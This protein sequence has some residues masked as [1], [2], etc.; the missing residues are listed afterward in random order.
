[1]NRLK[2]PCKMARMVICLQTSTL[3]RIHVNGRMTSNSVFFLCFCI[4][5]CYIIVQHKP[6]KCTFSDL[7]F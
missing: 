1:M 3:F 7:I 6:K 5:H 2:G 4:M